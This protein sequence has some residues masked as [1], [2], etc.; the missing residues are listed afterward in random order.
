MNADERPTAR[1]PATQRIF[2]KFEFNW[3]SLLI[4]T[5]MIAENT[6]PRIAF[7]GWESGES[8]V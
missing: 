4:P 2:S 5:P 8:I 7:R 3:K 6:W 1:A